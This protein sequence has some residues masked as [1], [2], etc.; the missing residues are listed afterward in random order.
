MLAPA[1]T[2][3]RRSAVATADQIAGLRVAIAEFAVRYGVT[4][5][6]LGAIRLAVSE[7]LTN[8][9]VHAYADDDAPGPVHCEAWVNRN[10]LYVV[11]ADEG[12][13]MQP[14]ADSPG[15][16]LGLPLLAQLVDDFRI[17]DDPARPGTRVSMCF[18]LDGSHSRMAA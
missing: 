5:K 4:P 14:R 1:D 3:L 9:V 13:G 17:A 12:R 15:L 18:S 10:M 2:T 8:V 6:L 16:G 7:A 11:V